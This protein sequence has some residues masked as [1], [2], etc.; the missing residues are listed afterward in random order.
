VFLIKFYPDHRSRL[1][2]LALLSANPT[3][4]IELGLPWFSK[5][6][7]VDRLQ[8]LIPWLDRKIQ[9]CGHPLQRGPPASTR[10]YDV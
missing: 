10:Y 4:S 1:G 9:F 8:E 3:N 7:D 6:V 5:G 2:M